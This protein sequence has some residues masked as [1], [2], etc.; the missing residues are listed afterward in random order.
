LTATEPQR[1]Q[2]GE[3]RA[4]IMRRSAMARPRP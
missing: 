4:E 1:R 3:F 2:F